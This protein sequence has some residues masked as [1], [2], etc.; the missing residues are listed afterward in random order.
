M[1]FLA[2][3]LMQTP[4]LDMPK[5]PLQE[6]KASQCRMP[7]RNTRLL[8]LRR[9]KSKQRG[10]VSC[11]APAVASQG[12]ACQTCSWAAMAMLACLPTRATFPCLRMTAQHHRRSVMTSSPASR[13]AHRC[14]IRH[15]REPSLPALQRFFWGCWN[16]RPA[17]SWPPAVCTCTLQKDMQDCCRRLQKCAR[18]SA[19]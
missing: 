6:H 13:S 11:R 3:F 19:Q 2:C 8:W 14:G 17:S 16:Q 9:R 10:R 1:M 7:L 15:G 4:F 5:E 18:Q 12:A